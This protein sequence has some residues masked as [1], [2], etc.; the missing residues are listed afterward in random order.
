MSTRR[1]AALAIT[2]AVLLT[3]SLAA[4]AA[5]TSAPARMTWLSA[6]LSPAQ[7]SAVE[8]DLTSVVPAARPFLDRL[9]PLVAFDTATGLCRGKAWSCSYANEGF[10]GR[11]GIHLDPQTM[12]ATY[13]SNRFLVYHEIGHAEWGLVMTDAQHEAFADAVRAALGGRPCTDGLDRPCAQIQEV[14]ADEFARWVGGFAVSMSYY[15]TPPLL[16]AAT[17]AA[18]LS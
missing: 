7:R 13:P 16:D 8:R 12:S 3:P 11:W 18:V 15:E 5:V 2:A 6:G 17:F 10:D 14:F 1:L 9:A 4:R